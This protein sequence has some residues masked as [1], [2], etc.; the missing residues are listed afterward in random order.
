MG[1]N[2]TDEPPT[3][4]TP[5]S[6][7]HHAKPPLATAGP[8]GSR[9]R[10]DG[11]TSDETQCNRQRRV[12]R[13]L[14]QEGNLAITLHISTHDNH[15]THVSPDRESLSAD[16]AVGGWNAT[17]QKAAGVLTLTWQWLVC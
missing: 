16:V 2:A 10:F 8:R 1:C 11:F 15:T 12:G 7:N 13:Q 4:V 14:A 9:Y 17:W 3:P 5:Y 6:S